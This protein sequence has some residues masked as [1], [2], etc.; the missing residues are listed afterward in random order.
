MLAISLTKVFSELILDGDQ[1][2]S[3]TYFGEDVTFMERNLRDFQSGGSQINF[4]A[5]KLCEFLSDLGLS[6][7]NQIIKSRVGLSAPQTLLHAPQKG[8]LGQCTPRGLG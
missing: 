1:S 3:N 8:V 2:P 4:N 7:S 6:K 5:L